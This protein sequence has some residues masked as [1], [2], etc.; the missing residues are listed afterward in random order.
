MISSVISRGS[1][2]VAVAVLLA[3][4]ASHA[5]AAKD[6]VWH[7]EACDGFGSKCSIG[8]KE[9]LEQEVHFHLE[10]PIICPQDSDEACIVVVNISNSHPEWVAVNPCM[11][12]WTA[13]E[14][15][16]TKTVKV[17]AVQD[18]VH[19]NENRQVHLSTQV[20]GTRSE[21]YL[22]FNPDD[23]YIESKKTGSAQC[24]ATGDPH[25]TTFDGKYWHFYDGNRR[26]PT[27][28]TYYKSTTRDFVMQVQV[29]G[30]PAVACAIAGREGNDR[31]MINN[32]GGGVSVQA[33]YQTTKVEDQPRIDVSGSTYT[34]YFKSGAWIRASTWSGG[35]NVYT[36]SVDPGA[37]CGACGN[38]NGNS[39]DDAVAY[40]VRDYNTLF[41]CQKVCTKALEPSCTC[42]NGGN[43]GTTMSCD[44]WEYTPEEKEESSEKVPE[45][46]KFCPFLP[47]Y[48]KPLIGA[49]DVE[50]LTDF[51]KQHTKEEEDRGVFVFDV[52]Q[53]DF[54]AGADKIDEKVA[55][56]Q[57][58][59]A[60]NGND[61]EANAGANSQLKAM[62]SGCKSM[63][64]EGG[65]AFNE[66]FGD[67][68]IDC[69]EDL[70]NLGGKE[71]D[72]GKQE[73]I[74]AVLILEQ[75][76]IELFIRFGHKFCQ[77]DISDA[78]KVTDQELADAGCTLTTVSGVCTPLIEARSTQKAA[79]A[80]CTGLKNA[81]CPEQCNGDAQGS[82]DDAA[83][84]C[85]EG[86]AGKSCGISTDD[87]PSVTAISDKVCDTHSSNCP[88]ELE[89]SGKGF[90]CDKGCNKP[91][92]GWGPKCVYESAGNDDV[93]VDAQF[94]G[95]DLVLCPVPRA[96]R[97]LGTHRGAVALKTTL[98]VA[99]VP[100][101][102]VDGTPLY[103]EE[104][105]IFTFFDSQCTLCDEDAKCTPN[106]NTC[107]V[108]V[109]GE[110]QCFRNGDSDPRVYSELGD[111]TN[112]C[113]E[114]VPSKSTTD[115]SY[116]F[117]EEE[118]KPKFDKVPVYEA[119]I[120]GKLEKGAVKG[121]TV[122]I[123]NQADSALIINGADNAYVNS[124]P[125]YSVTY[126]I[127][128]APGVSGAEEQLIKDMFEVEATTGQIIL[129]EDVDI[130]GNCNGMV[131]VLSFHWQKFFIT[132]PMHLF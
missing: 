26:Q 12:V 67:V 101:A 11:L 16:Q 112:P 84:V 89:I 76:C 68:L 105:M 53:E 32:C 80:K 19:E 27:R 85:K 31:V 100:K 98:R 124:A 47:S 95:E 114:C 102:D 126:K 55:L 78:I 36:Q 91:D 70:A 122:Y 57:C 40:V 35:M 72:L 111:Q 130:D 25:Y 69:S 125:D 86:W 13:A 51:L 119:I 60:M 34:V 66:K 117:V 82:C 1:A 63:D 110:L 128:V 17:T 96:S 18:Y 5:N 20:V 24:R 56:K 42:R 2:A 3:G 15:H 22:G 37:S 87:A 74:E 30:N 113:L 79:L 4:L 8:L 127:D 104:A 132:P 62:I 49:Q 73:L 9:G 50:D 71:T 121:A 75:T 6:P 123:D 93:V 106:P 131:H 29:R 77:R 108:E 61:A 43:T 92:N 39:G 44:I 107:Q 103:S 81:L 48:V 52:D 7:S 120:R 115:F 14:W 116:N 97:P 83:C 129:N 59:A 90:Y 99:N 23:I 28:L 54:D 10:E 118:C 65:A 45:A 38:F 46:K 109:N 33:S 21:L 64:D 58:T 41:E 94:S 88:D